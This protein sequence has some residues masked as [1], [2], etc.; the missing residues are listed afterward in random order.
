M[1]V[2][3][4]TVWGTNS[5]NKGDGN[6]TV[7]LTPKHARIFHEAG[8]PKA[9]IKDWLF[10]HSKVPE[11]ELPVEPRLMGHARVMDGERICICKEAKDIAILVAGGPENYHLA[12]LAN[13]GNPMAM[14]KVRM[15]QG[16]A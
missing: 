6:P 9:R 1:L 4:M 12:F 15:P 7:I 3:A 5:Y 16:A 10:E 14:A 2:N 13:Y 8:W 11:S